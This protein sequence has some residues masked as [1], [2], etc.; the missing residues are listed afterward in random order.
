MP[1]PKPKKNETKDKFISRCMSNKTMQNEFPDDEQRLAVCNNQWDK[2]RD[3]SGADKETR[4]FVISELRAEQKDEEGK[5]KKLVGHA[6]LF[7][8]ITDLGWFREKIEPGAF[9]ETIKNDDIRALWNHDKNF[10][11]GRTSAETLSLKEEKKGLAVEIDPPPTT[12]ANDLM[13]SIER[14]DVSQMSFAFQVTKEEWNYADKKNE[15]DLRTL[16]KVKLFDV[17]PVTFPAYP[18]TDVALR[19]FEKWEDARALEEAEEQ[20]ENTDEDYNPDLEYY[21]RRLTIAEL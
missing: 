19:S 14:G 5:Q 20:Q 4:F 2:K 21:K 13:V 15:T 6:A 17:S 3:Q 16:K 12:W 7:N 11:L 8:K 18:D 1:L 10:V 9:A